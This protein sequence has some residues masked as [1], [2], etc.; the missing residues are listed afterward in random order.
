MKEC[1]LVVLDEC[2]T[3]SR[4]GCTLSLRLVACRERMYGSSVLLLRLECAC[5]A[6]LDERRWRDHADERLF[7]DVRKAEETPPLVANVDE[8]CSVES[9]VGKRLGAVEMEGSEQG[10]GWG[11]PDTADAGLCSA[12]LG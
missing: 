11:A 7:N 1:S 4:W 12:L 5:L 6:K 10:V 2:P 8:V 9:R 3:N